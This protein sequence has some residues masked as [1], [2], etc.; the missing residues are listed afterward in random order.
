MTYLLDR[1]IQNWTR[2]SAELIGT[3][4]LYTDYRVEVDAVRRELEQILQR[5]PLWNRAVPSVLQVTDCKQDTI[6]LR[7]LCS[8]A[9]AA[10][11]WDLRCFVRE[12]LLA[13]LRSLDN[14]AFLP[15]T[16]VE[17]HGRTQRMAGEQFFVPQTPHGASP[18][19]KEGS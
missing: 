5:T 14:G 18:T 1:P 8:A 15:R 11:A 3:V 10:R 13:D 7:A 9:D 16:R 2:A 19:A 6:A 12:H 17:L 4:Y